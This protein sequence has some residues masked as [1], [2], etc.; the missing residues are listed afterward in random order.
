[1]SKGIG[2]SVRRQVEVAQRVCEATAL[3]SALG[4]RPGRP[5]ISAL[6]YEGAPWNVVAPVAE[7]LSV[8]EESLIELAS[9]LLKPDDELR[10]RL[11]HLAVLGELLLSL[12]LGG[13]GLI[14]RTPLSGGNQRPAYEV[15][16]SGGRRWDLWF[17]AAGAWSYY[18]RASPYGQAAI[19]VHGAGRALG[20]DLMLIRLDAEAL[21]IE[22][23]YSRNPE[24][25]ARTGYE[26]LLAYA[27]EIGT[28]MAPK[29]TAAVVGPEDVVLEIGFVE[30]LVG[31]VGIVP[32]SAV[33]AL[34]ARAL[35]NPE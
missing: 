2:D 10:W 12:K 23:K 13:A 33:P 4:I 24:V 15:T 14:S 31:S 35:R 3:A 18:Q 6:R 8:V 22:C 27:T 11:F 32:P 28:R 9:R 29:V 1:M 7:E 5:E 20:A 16:D 30:T 19:G 25:V 17:E 34:V 26:Q 21:I